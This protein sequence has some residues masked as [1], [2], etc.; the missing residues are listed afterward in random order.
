[1]NRFGFV[2]RIGLARHARQLERVLNVTRRVRRLQL[3]DQPMYVTLDAPLHRQE[4]CGVAGRPQALRIGLC[5]TLILAA[6]RVRK[7]DVLDQPLLDQRLKRQRRFALGRS[8]G[9]DHAPCD[10]VERLSMART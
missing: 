7:G 1:M 6:Q 5:E 8:Q 3:A 4:R 2:P 10:I 9:I